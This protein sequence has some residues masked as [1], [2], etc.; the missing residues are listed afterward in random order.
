MAGNPNL[1]VIDLRKGLKLIGGGCKACCASGGRDIHIWMSPRLLEQQA[2][3]VADTLSYHFPEHAKLYQKNLAKHLMELK[4]LD[5]GMGAILKT[6]EGRT[7]LVTHPDYTYFCTDY[8]L[9]QLPIEFEGKDP[10][11]RQLTDLLPRRGF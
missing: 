8:G 7:V 10:S 4:Q 2:K 5:Q 9:H 6:I 11:P 1:I 3:T